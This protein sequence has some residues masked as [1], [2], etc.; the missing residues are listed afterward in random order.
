[1]T[2]KGTT[3]STVLDGGNPT[4]T[5]TVTFPDK[6]FVVAPTDSPVFTGPVVVPNALADNQA[7]SRGQL[8]QVF[9]VRDEKPTTVAG[10]DSVAGNQVRVLNTVVRNTIVGASLATNQ[11][12]LPAGKYS[13]F[14]SAPNYKGDRHRIRLVN[15]TDS[16]IVLLGTSE[17]ANS[18]YN[19]G[20]HSLITGI[21][22]LTETKALNITHYITTAYAAGGLGVNA[23]D[24]FIEVYTSVYITKI[25]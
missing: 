18:S 14:A 7:L 23:S 3:F 9:H 22:T 15:V 8:D 1:M 13:I 16:T 17:Y 24:N 21:F 4:A 25:G 10:G 20:T 2:L 6:D 19:V 5:R 12:T 11:I